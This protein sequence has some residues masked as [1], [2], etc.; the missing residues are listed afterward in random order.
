MKD[1]EY[2]GKQFTAEIKIFPIT[3]VLRNCFK[4]FVYCCAHDIW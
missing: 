3:Q 4:L 2:G 1:G